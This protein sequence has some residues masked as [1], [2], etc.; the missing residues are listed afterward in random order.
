MR[1]LRIVI[2]AA[3]AYGVERADHVGLR[4]GHG[5]KFAP[6]VVCIVYH[7]I[8]ICV[9]NASNVAQQVAQIIIRRAVQLE[10]HHS[11]LI[12]N[13]PNDISSRYL[14]Q[15][16]SAAVQRYRSNPRQ[17]IIR[18]RFQSSYYSLMAGRVTSRL[19]SL[20]SFE[21][22]YCVFEGYL[23]DFLAA[24]YV[25]IDIGVVIANIHFVDQ[26]VNET[27]SKF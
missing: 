12:V 6:T 26:V 23:F 18:T 27:A 21:S 2:V 19:N 10:A 17:K 24:F 22:G 11:V 8:P 20:Y 3:I 7:Y 14:S 16:T 13:E 5:N 15:Q 9:N 1:Q 25:E 4:A